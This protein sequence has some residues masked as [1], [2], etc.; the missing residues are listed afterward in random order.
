MRMASGIPRPRPFF[1]H[2]TLLETS[3]LFLSRPCTSIEPQLSPASLHV[4]WYTSSMSRFSLQRRR[5]HRTVNHVF[6]PCSGMHFKPQFLDCL[7]LVHAALA[8]VCWP[9]S[10][11][12]DCCRGR[13]QLRM[14]LARRART[15]CQSVDV[16]AK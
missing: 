4:S 10:L 1:K 11:L 12:V 3:V 15:T 8:N 2:R 16:H 13:C 14:C 7:V 5:R 9:S 6:L